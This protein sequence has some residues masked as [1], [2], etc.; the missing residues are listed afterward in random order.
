[1][2]LAQGRLNK[3]FGTYETASWP[4]VPIT[5]GGTSG[6]SNITQGSTGSDLSYEATSPLNL[7]LKNEFKDEVAI[8]SSSEN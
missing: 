3:N 7:P 2:N 4:V 1:L 8:A 5:A 6:G